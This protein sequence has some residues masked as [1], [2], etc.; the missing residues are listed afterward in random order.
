MKVVLLISDDGYNQEEIVNLFPDDY[1]LMTNNNLDLNRQLFKNISQGLVLIDSDSPEAVKWFKK[2]LIIKPELVYIAFGQNKKKAVSLTEF[3]YDY[4]PIPCEAWQLKKI[5]DRAWEKAEQISDKRSSKGFTDKINK[6]VQN[7]QYQAA[8][9]WPRVLSDF[10]RALNA[11]FKQDKFLGLFLNAVKELV[12]V[13]K[14]A[15][16]LR[17][18]EKDIYTVQAQ[19]GLDPIIQERLCFKAGE[20]IIGWLSDK[21]LILRIAEPVIQSDPDYSTE[22][23]QEMKMLHADIAIPLVANGD[24]I[25][26]LCLGA[27]V[28]G[29]SF[30]E[31]ELELLY[32]IC[33]NVAIALNDID[34]HDRLYN[35]KIYIESILQL[36]NSGVVAIDNK[37]RI[38]TF[39]QRAAEIVGANQ[40][41]MIGRDLRS[42]PS[43]MGDMLY[44]TLLTGRAYQKEEIELPLGT[45]PLEIS[46]YRMI[47]NRE[48][49]EVIGSVMIFDDITSRKQ[50]EMERR[51]V[52]QLE[53]LNRFVSQLT[54]EIKNPM[55]AIQTFAQ[56][57]PEKYHDTAFRDFFSKTVKQEVKRLN[58]LVDQLIAFSSQLLYQYELYDVKEI[59]EAAIQLI[60]EQGKDREIDIEAHFDQTKAV[61]KADKTCLSR[62]VSYLINYFIEAT[63]AGVTIHIETDCVVDTAGDS[64]MNIGITDTGTKI[65]TEDI[66]KIFNPLFISP[67]SPISLGLP[68]SKKII[69]DHGGS[70]G[71]CQNGNSPL[72]FAISLPVIEN[73]ESERR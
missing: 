19:G 66:E 40:E 37:D 34:L 7:E 6:H 42:L 12:P 54:H 49:V 13:G 59:M 31:Y 73:D 11:H 56:L 50:V 27:K 57:L 20:G 41:D 5:L 29:A 14:M 18:E 63:G 71:V 72:R 53:V 21:G 44:E 9:N 48:E 46:T 62:A 4:L 24:L 60:H 47:S 28:T 36:M 22:L 33:G 69:E 43:P 39:N 23:V 64:L 51:Q 38:M 25:G 70:L 2:A 8:G 15:I 58:E 3:I 17:S 26:A 10:S 16:L 35:Q 61:I 67:E 65:E 1:F 55:V 32:S 68:V 30:Y 45:M 52:E